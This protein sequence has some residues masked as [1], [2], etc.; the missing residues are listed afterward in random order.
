ML[1]LLLLNDCWWLSE[2]RWLLIVLHCA[3]VFVGL[4][5]AK[6][7]CKE[8]EKEKEWFFEY[9]IYTNNLSRLAVAWFS[10]TKATSI[11]PVISA[12]HEYPFIALYS[13][14]GHFSSSSFIPFQCKWQ[15]F[16][17]IPIQIIIEISFQLPSAYENSVKYPCFDLVS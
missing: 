14:P 6:G 12:L 1:F 7:K 16:L 11:L 10:R 3:W 5:K 17:I 9:P 8:F 4:G 15:E 13:S 2:V